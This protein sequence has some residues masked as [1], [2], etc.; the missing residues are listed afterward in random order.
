MQTA[1][2]PYL[3]RRAAERRRLAYP[4]VLRGADGMRVSWGGIWGGVLVAMGTLLLMTALGLAIGITT[5]DPGATELRT[6][7]TSAGIW[8]VVSLLA[9]LFIGG[10][11]STRIG[12]VFDRTT[13]I[14]EGVLVWVVAVL[15]M[16]GFAG[17]GIGLLSSGAFNLV[18]GVG[19]AASALVQREDEGSGTVDLSAADIDHMV[20][21]L[22]DPRIA[23]Q[24]ST[25]TGIPLR[26][27]QIRLADLA[28]RIDVARDDPALAAA[29]IRRSIGAM[30]AQAP[31]HEPRGES[32]KPEAA[33]AWLTFAALVLSLAAAVLG[34]MA[35]RRDPAAALPA[36]R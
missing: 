30:V 3:E 35:G 33:A 4:P 13:G 5:I 17:S 20:A 23:Q 19:S 24:L 31:G 18:S 8:T 28:Q 22:G 26:E 34:A 2:G 25:M 10:L 29:E 27:M 15:L 6:L 14:F 36:E 16:A 21:K 11:V 1:T 12:A 9:A 7:A 32:A